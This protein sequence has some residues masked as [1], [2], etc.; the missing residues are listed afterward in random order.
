MRLAG[1]LF[2]LIAAT[3]LASVFIGSRSGKAGAVSVLGSTS[4]QPFAEMLAQEF[5]K[6]RPD[7]NVEVQGGGSTAGIEDRKSVV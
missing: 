7:I 4:V 2:G 5:H 6:Q 3:I 1:I